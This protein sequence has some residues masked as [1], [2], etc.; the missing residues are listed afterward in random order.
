MKLLQ[1]VRELRQEVKDLKKVNS[2]LMS[3]MYD[4]RALLDLIDPYDGEG[5]L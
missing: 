4:Y 1:E 2:L 3:K 5:V